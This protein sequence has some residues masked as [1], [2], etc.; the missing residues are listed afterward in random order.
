MPKQEPEPNNQKRSLMGVEM[1]KH[2]LIR[3]L[4]QPGI[5]KDKM[6]G[7][8]P[9]HSR[10]CLLAKRFLNESP[11]TLIDVGS[12]RGDF[13]K[14]AKF[15]FPNIKVYSFDINDNTG[16]WNKNMKIKFHKSSDEPMQNT[17]FEPTHFKPSSTEETTVKRFDSLKLSIERPC[18]VKL[19]VEGAEYQVLEGFG[20]RLKEV[21]V[22]Q[23]EEVFSDFFKNRVRLSQI[24]K[25]LENYG[26]RGFQQI[27]ITVEGSKLEKCD[28]LFFK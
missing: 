3:F 9:W 27:N 19:D 4:E 16:L 7:I 15:H 13:S 6:Y 5:I 20:D 2:K 17:L 1:L 11:K 25:L 24:M 26:F 22:L 12:N 14:A 28:L 8:R 18:L 21:D 10:S 23:L